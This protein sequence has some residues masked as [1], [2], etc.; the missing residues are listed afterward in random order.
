[1]RALCSWAPHPSTDWPPKS[2]GRIVSAS[3]NPPKSASIISFLLFV[4]FLLLFFYILFLLRKTL[5]FFSLLI[6]CTCKEGLGFFIF[7]IGRPLIWV[8]LA[9]KNIWKSPLF[10]IVT[11]SG[12]ERIFLD[13]FFLFRKCLKFRRRKNDNQEKYVCYLW[14]FFFRSL[15]IL[16]RQ[17]ISNNLNDHSNIFFL[18]LLSLFIWKLN[19]N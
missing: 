4:V 5:F 14:L 19:F 1:M 18:L 8:T 7:S 2:V 10:F 3:E 15:R 16:S 6:L 9:K 13:F 12:S 11:Y 17:K